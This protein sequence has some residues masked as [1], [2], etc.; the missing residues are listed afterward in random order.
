MAGC[1]RWRHDYSDTNP[2]CDTNLYVCVCAREFTSAKPPLSNTVMFENVT[3]VRFFCSQPC[4]TLCRLPTVSGRQ[5]HYVFL[6][7][8]YL[9]MSWFESPEAE[10][11]LYLKSASYSEQILGRVTL[12]SVALWAWLSRVFD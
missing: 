10:K 4:L 2:E 1:S 8:L 3:I 5:R 6:F 11:R 12:C 9:E 7:G